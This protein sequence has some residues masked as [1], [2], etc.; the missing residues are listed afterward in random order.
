MI[1]VLSPSNF[2]SK[3][4]NLFIWQLFFKD[5]WLC[6]SHENQFLRARENPFLLLTV[7]TKK[8]SFLEAVD[9]TKVTKIMIFRDAVL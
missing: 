3:F 7:G 2:I 6:K 9:I 5:G 8:H 1:Y 4:I